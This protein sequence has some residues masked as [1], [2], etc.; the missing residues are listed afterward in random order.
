M[1]M[2]TF[3]HVEEEIHRGSARLISSTTTYRSYRFSVD[4]FNAMEVTVGGTS[5][6][7]IHPINARFRR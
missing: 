1:T 7:S 4:F 2:I 6:C 3:G 5:T